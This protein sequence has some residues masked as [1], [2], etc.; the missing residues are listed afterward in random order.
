MNIQSFHYE[1]KLKMDRVDTMSSTDFN[2]AEI[3]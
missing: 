2:A 1:F 3:D